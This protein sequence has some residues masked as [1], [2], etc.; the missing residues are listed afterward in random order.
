M[1]RV[2]L[3]RFVGRSAHVWLEV[4]EQGLL[5]VLSLL[6]AAIWFAACLL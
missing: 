1:K 5:L 2:N 3:T 4:H 6:T